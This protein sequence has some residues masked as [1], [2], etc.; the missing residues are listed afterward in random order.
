MYS[1]IYF[2]NFPSEFETK[3]TAHMKTSNSTNWVM[4]YN[5][6]FRLGDEDIIDPMYNFMY[7]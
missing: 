1:E 4:K 3:E 6:A 5:D 2:T 7:P